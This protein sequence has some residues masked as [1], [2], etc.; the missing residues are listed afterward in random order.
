MLKTIEIIYKDDAEN[1]LKVVDTITAE[2]FSNLDFN[3]LIYTYQS[4]KPKKTLPSSEI[5]R[6]SDKV[7][8]RALAQEVTGNRVIY[9]NYVDGYTAMNTLDY[10]VS[11]SEKD[12]V[13]TLKK[14]YPN[15]TLKQNR[16]Y[17]VGVV[18]V[19][20]YGRNSDVI[21]SSLDL[22][23]TDV[24]QVIYSGSTVFHSFYTDTFN[25]LDSNTTWNGDALKVK[26]NSKIPLSIPQA[27]YPGLFLGYITNPASNLY[28]GGGYTSFTG[29]TT[30]GGTGTG[31]TVNITIDAAPLGGG[32]PSLGIVQSVTINNPGIGYKQ[33]DVI[34]ITGG[35]PSIQATF[36][37]NPSSQPNLTGWYS[38]KIVVKQTEQDYYNVYLPGWYS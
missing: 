20:R 15:H 25:L 7:P 34:T 18:L 16:S 3:T 31:L 33:G 23:N 5:T 27:G 12:E 38:Y 35:S 36:V 4:R 1:S 9:G 28:G 24:S 17:Q 10:E 14:E 29:L 21:L 37:Y 2:S 6:V 8:I 13:T 32:S 19:D 26:F 11:A 22:T 30:S